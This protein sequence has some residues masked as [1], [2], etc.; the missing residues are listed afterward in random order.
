MLFSR[1]SPAVAREQAVPSREMSQE[2][3]CPPLSRVPSGLSEAE[4]QR[5][6]W[7]VLRHV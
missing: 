5:C 1:V 7:G 4:R 6:A 2:T 3:A